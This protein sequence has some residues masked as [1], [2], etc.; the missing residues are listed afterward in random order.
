M[1]IEVIKNEKNDIE[2][3]AGSSTVLELLRSYLYK[4][5]VEFAAWKRE[6]PSKPFLMKIQSSNKPAKKI[7]S[8]AIESVKK[9]CDKILGAVKK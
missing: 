4:E 5:G 2:F 9:D 8:D 1:E 6:H 3:T 7:I